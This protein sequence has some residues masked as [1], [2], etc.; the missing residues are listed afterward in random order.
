[1]PRWPLFL[2]SPACLLECCG[3]LSFCPS[4]SRQHCNFESFFDHPRL[5]V[6]LH[7][8]TTFNGYLFMIETTYFFPIC[9]W[10]PLRQDA[11]LSACLTS[12]WGLCLSS[13][14]H[15]SYSQ[16]GSCRKHVRA[17]PPEWTATWAQT[18]R[19]ICYSARMLYF[20]TSVSTYRWVLSFQMCAYVLLLN[21]CLWLFFV[22]IIILYICVLYASSLVLIL[23]FTLFIKQYHVFSVWI[24]FLFI[25]L[26]LDS[27]KYVDI[28]KVK[29]FL[30]LLLLLYCNEGF[31][32]SISAMYSFFCQ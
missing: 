21:A 16:T 19:E 17:H 27:I 9:W 31:C 26:C 20:E 10:W 13:E 22:I 23:C 24:Y 8:S 28:V 15:H 32:V 29:H 11:C 7:F 25:C 3:V 14:T 6:S 5:G 4:Q 1:M 18:Q 2:W 30:L 12:D